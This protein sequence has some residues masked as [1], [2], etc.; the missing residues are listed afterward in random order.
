METTRNAQSMRTHQIIGSYRN[1]GYAPIDKKSIVGHLVSAIPK[2]RLHRVSRGLQL[3][4]YSPELTEEIIDGVSVV[5]N[6]LL[7]IENRKIF[8]HSKT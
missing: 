3:Q 6:D 2:I 5:L 4:E 7:M 1:G 8:F